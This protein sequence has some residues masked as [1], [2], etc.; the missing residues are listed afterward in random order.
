VSSAGLLRDHTVYRYL[1]VVKDYVALKVIIIIENDWKGI[2]K[3]VV[4]VYLKVV[5][6]SNWPGR[7]E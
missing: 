7:A 3:E 4:V 1:F 6:F 2:W 5:L